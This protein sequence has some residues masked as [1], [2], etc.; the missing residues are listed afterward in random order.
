MHSTE[1]LATHF[2]DVVEYPDST[3][4]YPD[5][6]NFLFTF[7]QKIEK[8]SGLIIF[9]HNLLS[10][11]IK[12]LNYLIFYFLIKISPIFVR[13][14]HFFSKNDHKSAQ[15]CAPWV[16]RLPIMFEN[17]FEVICDHII[18]ARNL[19]DFPKAKKH[20]ITKVRCQDWLATAFFANQ[21][22]QLWFFVSLLWFLVFSRRLDVTIHCFHFFKTTKVF[23]MQKG[24]FLIFFQRKKC[25]SG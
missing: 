10:Q 6:Q 1:F 25:C 9:S 19:G 2:C 3:R 21:L 11:T 20:N 24:N 17:V 13:Y 16:G 12:T 15:I 7:D 8:L 4:D 18:H 22:S 23:L 5:T 14:F